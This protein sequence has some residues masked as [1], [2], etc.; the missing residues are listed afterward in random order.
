[1][2]LCLKVKR[3]TPLGSP[4]FFAASRTIL[5]QSE[6]AQD[7]PSSRVNKGASGILSFDRQVR[8]VTTVLIV[9]RFY[10]S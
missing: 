5:S 8:L 3:Q 7:L 4:A 10:Q 9:V 1:M 2:K 6:C